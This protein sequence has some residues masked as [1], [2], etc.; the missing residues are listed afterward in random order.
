[1]LS[2][3]R[4]PPRSEPWLARKP[5][6]ASR[7]AEKAE[8]RSPSGPSRCNTTFAGSA[9]RSGAAEA[10][11]NGRRRA[12]QSVLARASA[13]RTPS[14]DS[15]RS[16][17]QETTSAPHV[18]S[19]FFGTSTPVSSRSHDSV[20]CEGAERVFLRC[21]DGIAPTLV[22]SEG[23]SLRPAPSRTRGGGKP[24]SRPGVPSHASHHARYEAP[25]AL[26]SLGSSE[27]GDFA[28][29]SAVSRVYLVRGKHH[30]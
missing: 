7:L 12:I 21:R 15:S 29:V 25:A 20:G 2:S 1:V 26:S 17:G 24:Q 5:L 16:S 28:Q 6:P 19:Q 9:G 3:G 4:W 27:K 22:T 30:R 13:R 8:R 18:R 23:P 11:T 10:L 14:D